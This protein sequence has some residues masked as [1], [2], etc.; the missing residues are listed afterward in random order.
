MAALISV[1]E[2]CAHG[3]TRDADLRIANSYS[4]G[5]L[6]ALNIA[7]ELWCV[8]DQAHGKRSLAEHE[9][10]RSRLNI[11][12]RSRESSRFETN[13]VQR[14]PESNV[15]YLLAGCMFRKEC[16]SYYA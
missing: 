4:R 10:G 15:L 14:T 6:H 7:S 13:L 1:A 3:R 2:R 12:W 8:L 16:F 5:T 9:G 11:A